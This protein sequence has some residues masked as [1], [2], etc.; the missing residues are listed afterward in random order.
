MT[1]IAFSVNGAL[2]SV[3]VEDHWTLLEVLRERLALT[4]TKRGCGMGECGAC[5][6]IVNGRAVTSCLVLARE[7][8]GCE[9][10]TIEGEA[11]GD[12]LSD[13]QQAFIDEGAIQCGFCTSGMIMSARALLEKNPDPDEEQVKVAMEG[14]LCRCTGY[15]PIVAAILEAARR[16]R[17]HEG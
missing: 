4:G 8:D 5:T 14:N 9:V 13:L 12:K 3:D 11:D 10:R 7:V 17:D 6:V 1:R 16:E 2:V 15:K